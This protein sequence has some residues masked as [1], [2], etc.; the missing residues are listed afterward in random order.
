MTKL[1]MKRREAGITQAEL[2]NRA[3]VSAPFMCDLEAGKRTA[4]QDTW[5]RIANALGCDPADIIES[6]PTEDKQ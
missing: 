5:E 6:V 4:R 1:K 3:L 2:A